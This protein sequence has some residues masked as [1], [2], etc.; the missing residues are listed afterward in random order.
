MSAVPLVD[1]W[2]DP[3]NLMTSSFYV[4]LV[5]M[6]CRVVRGAARA[7]SAGGPVVTPASNGHCAYTS[8]G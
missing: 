8:D 1:T 4:S 3:R 7:S 2:S 6:T 5:L